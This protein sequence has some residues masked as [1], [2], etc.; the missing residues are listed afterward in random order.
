MVAWQAIPVITLFFSSSPEIT[1]AEICNLPLQFS[2]VTSEA[3]SMILLC[4]TSKKTVMGSKLYGRI[5]SCMNG[6]NLNAK[7][8]DGSTSNLD[9][10]VTSRGKSQK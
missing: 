9:I 2:C 10:V 7:T 4:E 3:D 5:M 6:G 8:E 1:G